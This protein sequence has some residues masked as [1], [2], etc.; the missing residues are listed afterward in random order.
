MERFNEI[1]GVN[2]TQRDRIL[3]YIKQREEIDDLGDLRSKTLR[4]IVLDDL[5][6]TC[7]T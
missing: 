4:R 7:R 3:D 1:T 2:P 5:P 6:L